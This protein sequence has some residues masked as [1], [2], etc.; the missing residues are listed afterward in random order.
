[1]NVPGDGSLGPQRPLG[2]GLPFSL[3]IEVHAPRWGTVSGQGWARK[4]SRTQLTGRCGSRPDAVPERRRNGVRTLWAWP[5]FPG[6]SMARLCPPRACKTRL[7]ATAWRT[8]APSARRCGHGE[9]QP[10]SGPSRPPGGGLFQSLGRAVEIIVGIVSNPHKLRPGIR[11]LI[12]CR[13][14]PQ[15]FPWAPDFA[16]LLM[17]AQGR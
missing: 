7:V 1:L 6:G 15:P 12:G 16:D 4:R 5:R 10:G 17:V 8:V 2:H 14:A 9:A 13:R 3:V 11:T